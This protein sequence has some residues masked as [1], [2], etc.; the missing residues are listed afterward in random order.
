MGGSRVFKPERKEGPSERG[1][2]KLR[3]CVAVIDNE[4]VYGTNQ[5]TFK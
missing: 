2:L 5:Q 3:F 4:K 1:V